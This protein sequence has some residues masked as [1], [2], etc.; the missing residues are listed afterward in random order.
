MIRTAL[1]WLSDTFRVSHIRSAHPAIDVDQFTAQRENDTSAKWNKALVVV[2]SEIAIR[3]RQPIIDPG[4]SEDRIK[5]YV[6]LKILMKTK[7]VLYPRQEACGEE[8]IEV[9]LRLRGT[10]KHGDVMPVIDLT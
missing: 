4:G 7:S 10:P 6:C 2:N 9:S 3:G 1:K 8:I 5:S